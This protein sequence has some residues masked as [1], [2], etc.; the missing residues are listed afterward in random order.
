MILGVEFELWVVAVLC[1]TFFVSGFVDSIAGGGG[2]INVPVFLLLGAPPEF[3][4]GTTKMSATIG[5]IAA[6]INYAKNGLINW[7]LAFVGLPAAIIGGA[8]GTKAILYFDSANIGKIILFLL[9]VGVAAVLLPRRNFNTANT[10]TR[11]KLYAL[12]PMICFVLG[13]YDGFFGPGVGSFFII[14]LNFF[15]GLTLVQ[16]AAMT[17]VFNLST[18]FSSFVVFAVA[19]KVFFL[20]GI[21]L[22]FFSIAGNILGSSM[23]IKIGSDFVKKVLLF[24][25]SLLFATLA[26]KFFS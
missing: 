11:F 7:R 10:I 6:L 15:I 19:G 16:A 12:T 26:W 22:I 2:L 8:L 20:L 1:L 9:P 5:K 21:L 17:K 3:A 23:A 14:A 18:A 24:S 4:L 13:F 25:L